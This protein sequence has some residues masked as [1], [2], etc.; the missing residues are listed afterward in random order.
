MTDAM[1]VTENSTLT[2]S[3][4]NKSY[5]RKDYYFSKRSRPSRTNLNE[6]NKLFILR[7][8]EKFTIEIRPFASPLL[9]TTHKHPY[10]HRQR[11][12]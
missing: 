4:P 2:L 1:T 7:A 8:V 11:H 6:L 9:R 10:L 5:L 12:H 3:E